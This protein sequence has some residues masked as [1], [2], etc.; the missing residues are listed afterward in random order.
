MGDR[1]VCSRAPDIRSRGDACRRRPRDAL[2]RR[3]SEWAGS[4]ARERGTAMSDLSSFAATPLARTAKPTFVVGLIASVLFLVC[5]FLAP[6][7]FFRA[8]LFAWLTCL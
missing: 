7:A 8:Y 3:R 4:R 2:G 6:A 1:R 5:G